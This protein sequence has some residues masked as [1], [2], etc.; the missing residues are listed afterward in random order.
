MG[1]DLR[2]TNEF[3]RQTRKNLEKG[4]VTAESDKLQI[5]DIMLGALVIIAAVISLTDFSFSIGSIANITALT[6]FLYLI[7]TFVYRNRYA[8]GVMRGKREEEYISSLEEYRQ[9]RDWIYNNNLAG[10]VPAFCT[11]YKKK[12]LREYRESLLSDVEIPYEEYAEKYLKLPKRKI[13]A[14]PLSIEAKKIILKCNAAKSIKLMPGMILNENGEYSRHKLI[15][16]SGKQREIQDKRKNAIT[17]A[18]YVLFGGLIVFDVIFNFSLQTCLQWLIR[19][20][21][22]VLAI[23]TGDDSGYCNISVTEVAFKKGQSNVIN[24][25]SEYLEEQK[26]LPERKEEVAEASTDI[27][28][29]I[30]S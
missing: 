5:N 23:I 13:M 10:Y 3:R 19:M 14:L 24:L 20:L 9:K 28:S 11:Y 4:I 17:R 27:M 1:E 21:P 12:E 15:G 2:N 6:I 18:V 29:D 7:T 8:K 25:F 16:K 26:I 22:V 30:K